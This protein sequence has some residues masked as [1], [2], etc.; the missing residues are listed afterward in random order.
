[1]YNSIRY[2][3]QV[4]S[5]E[6]ELGLTYAEATLVVEAAQNEMSGGKPD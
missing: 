1:M 6:T 4:T 2:L 3:D 5:M